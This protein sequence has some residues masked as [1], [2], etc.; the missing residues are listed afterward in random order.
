M[1]ATMERAQT[2]PAGQ[3]RRTGIVGLND[4]LPNGANIPFGGFKESGIGRENGAVGL[5]HFLE[6]KAVAMAL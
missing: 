3:A 4:P 5:E 6:V 2:A 1:A